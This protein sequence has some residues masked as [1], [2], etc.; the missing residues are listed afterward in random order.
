MAALGI[1]GATRAVREFRLA[2]DGALI[3]NETERIAGVVALVPLY[4]S[5][6]SWF[7]FPAV[8]HA[9]RQQGPNA[10]H[11]VLA[12]DTP[13]ARLLPPDAIR[14]AGRDEQHRVSA[15]CLK[16]ALAHPG[17]QGAQWQA[18]TLGSEGRRAG[19]PD[20]LGAARL[21]GKPVQAFL[22]QSHDGAPPT[23]RTQWLDRASGH[24][25]S[26]KT[27]RLAKPHWLDPSIAQRAVSCLLDA[28]YVWDMASAPAQSRFEYLDP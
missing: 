5:T 10:P 1:A 4:A 24:V 23:L 12:P 9:E 6:Q 15:Q 16:E 14:A 2:R 3:V 7:R 27:S 20:A 19:A 8:T 26:T 21:A 25:P 17:A 11:G 28:G 13:Y 18:A 22:F